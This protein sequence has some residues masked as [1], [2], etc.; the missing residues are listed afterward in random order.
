M[1]AHDSKDKEEDHF[2][3][4]AT[5][6]AKSCK[7]VKGDKERKVLAMRNSLGRFA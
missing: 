4:K 1:R 7:E 6:S 2:K 3:A 5:S